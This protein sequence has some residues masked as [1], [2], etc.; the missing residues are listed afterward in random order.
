MKTS[1][2]SERAPANAAALYDA[3]DRMEAAIGQE[4]AILRENRIVDLTDFNHRKHQGLLEI[5]RILRNFDAADL[6]AMDRTRV[7]RLVARLDDNQA[8]LSHH[9]H[10]VDAVAALLSRAMQ[11]A[12]SDGTYG[13]GGT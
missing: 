12:E 3:L 5:N 7:K 4:T 9:L 10:A 8:M 11:E 2:S 1:R 13:R 6:A